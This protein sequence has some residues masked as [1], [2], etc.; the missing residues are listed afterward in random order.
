MGS[1]NSPSHRPLLVT[2]AKQE[3]NYVRQV[4]DKLLLG[5]DGFTPLKNVPPNKRRNQFYSQTRI[6]DM[7]KTFCNVFTPGQ[8]QAAGPSKAPSPASPATA[9]SLI[10]TVHCERP[11][12]TLTPENSRRKHHQDFQVL[13]SSAERWCNFCLL[14][15]TR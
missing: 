3:S 15:Y 10:T 1:S 13:S 7:A 5:N 8:G 2:A 12:S 11:K 9:P 4:Q 14:A 6:T